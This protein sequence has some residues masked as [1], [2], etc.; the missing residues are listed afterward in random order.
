VE[1]DRRAGDLLPFRQDLAGPGCEHG[2]EH[3]ATGPGLVL[4]LQPVRA[5]SR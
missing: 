3:G 2:R 5:E 4:L 1:A